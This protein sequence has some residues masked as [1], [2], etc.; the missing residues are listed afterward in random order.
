MLSVNLSTPGPPN[1]PQEVQVSI[2]MSQNIDD[3]VQTDLI[4]QPKLENEETIDKPDNSCT[5]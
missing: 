1:I 4:A 2:G 3:M 5:S